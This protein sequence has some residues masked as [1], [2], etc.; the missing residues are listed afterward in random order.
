M[1]DERRTRFVRLYGAHADR[2]MAYCLRHL[3]PS[4]ANDALSDIFLTAWRRLDEVPDDAAPW[5]YVTARNVIRNHYRAQAASLAT[6]QRVAQLQ[7]LTTESAEVTA[8][9]RADLAT[10]LGALNDDEREALLL[11]AWDGLSGAEAARVL[12]CTPGA[13]RVRVHRARERMAAALRESD[14]TW[15]GDPT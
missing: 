14:L 13:L 6:A 11:T 7:R 8:E 4:T 3:S 2:I 15:T 1:T 9:R 12:G 10:A 5:L